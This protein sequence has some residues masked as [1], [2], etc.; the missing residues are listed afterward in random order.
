MEKRDLIICFGSAQ[1]VDFTPFLEERDAD[2]VT[3][4]DYLAVIVGTKNATDVFDYDITNDDVKSM[5]WSWLYDK[6]IEFVTPRLKGWGGRE[7]GAYVRE[8]F[9]RM[10]IQL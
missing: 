1:A 4:A 9:Q 6:A 5:G 7:Q 3:V 2:G 10:G 8:F